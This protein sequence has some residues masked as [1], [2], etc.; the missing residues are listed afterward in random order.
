MLPIWASL[1][2]VLWHSVNPCLSP[3]DT[4]FLTKKKISSQNV[5]KGL[6]LQIR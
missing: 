1:I 4:K 3:G 5:F 6:F 2:C